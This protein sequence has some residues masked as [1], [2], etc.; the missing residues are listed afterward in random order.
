MSA[1]MPLARA[2]A[3]PRPRRLRSAPTDA[4]L[5]GGAAS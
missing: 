3:A 5:A 4:A 1:A 2:S